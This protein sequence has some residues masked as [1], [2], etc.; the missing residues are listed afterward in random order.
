MQGRIQSLPLS[1]HNTLMAPNVSIGLAQSLIVLYN[2]Q[3]IVLKLCLH[4]LMHNTGWIIFTDVIATLGATGG[5][6][7]RPAEYTNYS[8]TNCTTSNNKH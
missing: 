7:E 6:M 5:I 4:V 3:L 2:S 8:L 1:L